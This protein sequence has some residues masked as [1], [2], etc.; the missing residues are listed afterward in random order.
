[1]DALRPRGVPLQRFTRQE[2]VV[3]DVDVVV[4]MTTPAVG[5]GHHEVVRAVHILGELAAKIIDPLDVVGVVHVELVGAEVLRVAVQ[6][7][8]APV[9]LAPGDELVGIVD[10]RGERGGAAGTAPPVLFLLLAAVAVQ[11][12]VDTGLCRVRR[13]DV[14]SAHNR[15]RSPASAR[16][17][18]TA[19]I[20]GARALSRSGSAS[21][22]RASS[23]AAARF[24]SS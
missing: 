5:V 7:D 17:A 24:S 23:R 14:D 10:G 11:G 2:V 18:S 21:T 1:M 20:T 3:A 4:E 12:V 8:L 22:A 15:V 19:V 16:S 9:V 13:P 6:L